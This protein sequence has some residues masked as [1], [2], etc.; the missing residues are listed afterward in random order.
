MKILRPRTIRGTLEAYARHPDAVPLA[1]ATDFMV[2]WNA[3]G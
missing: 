3:G 2:T 1:G